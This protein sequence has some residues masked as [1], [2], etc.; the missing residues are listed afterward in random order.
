MGEMRSFQ[1]AMPKTFMGKVFAGVVVIWF[2]VVA[3]WFVAELL[4][5]FFPA[6]E[7]HLRPFLSDF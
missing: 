5:A 2:A 1:L 6:M 4:A 3:L 7:P